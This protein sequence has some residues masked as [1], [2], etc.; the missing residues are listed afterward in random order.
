V[1]WPQVGPGAAPSSPGTARAVGQIDKPK[2]SRARAE[3]E[4]MTTPHRQ[5]RT[6][7]LARLLITAAILLAVAGTT[8]APDTRDSTQT[9]L[10]DA[11][12]AQHAPRWEIWQTPE[13]AYTQN[14]SNPLAGRVWGVYDGPQDQVWAP[15]QEATGTTKGHIARI[16]LRPRTKWYGSHLADGKV[17]GAVTRYIE[18][19]QD[20]DPTKLVQMAIFRMQPWEHEACQRPSTAAERASYRTWITR[21]AD[22]IGATPM[23]VVMQPDGPF[24]F[25]TPDRNVKA[26]LLTW[27][28]QTLSALPNTSVY[29]D[30]GAADWCENGK[31]NNPERCAQILKLT[32]IKYAR[33]FALDSTHYTGP[34]DNI[35]HGA[36]IVSIL[37]RDGYGTKHF[38]LDTAKSG[39]PMFW[40]D[41]IPTSGD[42]KDNARTCGTP[43]MTRCVTLGIP[44]T[45]RVAKSEWGLDTAE[46]DLARRYV[47]GFVWF[48][49]PWLYRQADPFV[50]TRAVRMGTSTPWQ[51]PKLGTPPT[52]TP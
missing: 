23:L 42:I 40:A 8:S 34:A 52:A 47:D 25:C 9:A 13:A 19:S 33:G 24:L 11:T 44:P 51:A 43:T 50:T 45:I 3:R 15:Y 20:G 30:A 4:S 6:R 2:D 49:R 35:H 38:I 46:R 21:L 22:A 36:K 37:R 27:A 32:G 16:A 1:I 31:G 28:T 26:S 29:I 7:C 39:R 18:A 17:T 5:R 12:T 48:G 10:A 41:V 14:P